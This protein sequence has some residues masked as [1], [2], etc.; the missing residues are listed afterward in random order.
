MVNLE[1]NQR[2]SLDKECPGIN[3][4]K[5]GLGWD[6]KTGWFEHNIDVDASVICIDNSNKID[7]IVYFGKKRAYNGAIRHGG[8]NL[9]GEGE[10]DDEVIEIKLNELPSN[11]STL[12]VIINIYSA[13]TRRQSFTK[14]KNCFVRIIDL[15]DN[16]E[17]VHYDVSGNFDGKTGIFVADFHRANGKWDFQ[18]IG[19]GVVAEDIDSM[20]KMR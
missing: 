18:A 17:I 13:R 20:S 5:V 19:R 1:K 2:I 16:Q 3:N 7:T 6:A 10:G 4:I 8:D 14:V 15:K 9:T 11:I 12:S